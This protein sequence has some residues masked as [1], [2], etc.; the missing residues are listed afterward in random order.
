MKINKR[1]QTDKLTVYKPEHTTGLYSAVFSIQTHTVS[2]L[3][4]W[5]CLSLYLIILFL[6]C[7]SEIFSILSL[8][9]FD[10]K[11]LLHKICL[12]CC[13]RI[14]TSKF[15]EKYR[16]DRWAVHIFNLSYLSVHTTA[17]LQAADTLKTLRERIIIIRPD[18]GQI[19]TF[20]ISITFFGNYSSFLDIFKYTWTHGSIQLKT[21]TSKPSP[22]SIGL[23]HFISWVCLLVVSEVLSADWLTLV[24]K[25]QL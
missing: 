18:S 22:C 20:W 17:F 5:T 4:S 8:L 23:F 21:H 11:N 19:K 2:L 10:L 13:D 7:K 9:L 6:F 12:T 3:D 15:C 1:K 25:V 24:T 16:C 14:L